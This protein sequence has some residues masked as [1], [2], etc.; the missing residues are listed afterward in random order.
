MFKVSQFYWQ[1]KNR[2]G[3]TEKG[4]CLGENRQLVEKRLAQKGFHHIRVSR[5][6]VLFQQAKSQEITQ[7]LN[8]F[9]LLVKSRIPLKTAL[10]LLWENSQNPSIYLWLKSIIQYLESGYSL[11]QALSKEAKYLRPQEIQLIQI[12]ETSGQLATILCNIASARTNTEKLAQKVKKILFYPTLILSFS[13]LLTIL[14]LLFIVPKF[15][16]LY[17]AKQQSLPLLTQL[18]FSSSQLLK[19][20]FGEII[21]L[22]GIISLISLWLYDKT[23]ILHRLKF[24]LFSLMPIFGTILRQS[25]TVFFCQNSAIMLNAHIRIDAVLQSFIATPKADPHLTRS[26]TFALEHLKQGYPLHESLSTGVFENDV[27]RMIE[28]GEKS[29]NLAEMLQHI[30]DNLQQ[31]LDYQIDLLSQLLEPLLML[32]LGTIVGVIMIGL[33]LPIFDMGGLVE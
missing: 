4:K 2:F 19:H 7:L 10:S 14:L 21:L 33:Y 5:N 6:I 12:G 23:D 27:I 1:G 15:A 8:Q 24:K 3:L 31:R 13:L 25:R 9:A 17:V 28:V 29:G 20:A 26:L 18:L 30:G 22:V 11:S 16:E 32:V